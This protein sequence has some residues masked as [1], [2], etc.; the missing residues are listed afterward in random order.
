M[1]ETFIAPALQ[2]EPVPVW[3]NLTEPKAVDLNTV[4]QKVCSRLSESFSQFGAII[5]CDDLPQV[6]AD[7]NEIMW[8][9]EQA[10]YM[11][12]NSSSTEVKVL[13]HIKKA[14]LPDTTFAHIDVC[15]SS[16]LTTNWQAQYTTL[17][18]KCK[19]ICQKHGGT[20]N[21]NAS[22]GG[23]SL[24]GIVLPAKQNITTLG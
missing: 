14:T 4:T 19:I 6:L 17:L 2:H 18:N 10:V 15:T 9:F 22:A 21:Y 24:F 3:L 8:V 7:D 12:L 1:N 11:I 13:I 20:F 5:R 23:S 16:K